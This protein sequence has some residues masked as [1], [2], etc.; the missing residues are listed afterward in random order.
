[1]PM[2]AGQA[3]TIAVLA[4]LVIALLLVTQNTEVH[5]SDAWTVL[6]KLCWKNA[7]VRPPLLVVLTVELLV[8]VL[9]VIHSVQFAA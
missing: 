1:M 2:E 8:L 7:T 6:G 3:C 4:A 5:H 9:V